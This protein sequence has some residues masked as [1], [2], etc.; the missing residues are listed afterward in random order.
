[1]LRLKFAHLFLDI[2]IKATDS[3]AIVGP[4]G[5]GKSIMLRVISH[6]LYPQKLIKREVFGKKLTLFEARKV[7]GV[8]DSNL[9]YFYRNE[10]ITVFDAVISAFKNALVVYDRFSFSET[11]KEDALRIIEKFSLNPH[12]LSKNLSLGE[13]KKMLIAR[14]VVHKPK[15]LCLDEPTNGL[16]IKAK[17]EFWE[18]IEMLNMKTILVTHD[19]SEAKVYSNIVMLSNGKAKQTDKLKK[20]DIIKLFNIDENIYRRFYG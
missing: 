4:N 20:E 5:S 19:F 3:F 15:I 10:N 1:M 6:E 12:A 7:F 17:A 16:D 8:V 2:D 18:L 9:E 11:Q 13:M 14:A